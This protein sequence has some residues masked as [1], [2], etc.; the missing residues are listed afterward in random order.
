MVY[1]CA[2]WKFRNK[3]FN[4]LKIAGYASLNLVKLDPLKI[5]EIDIKQG[6]ESPVNINLKIQNSDLIGI[7][8]AKALQVK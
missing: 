1:T 6:K 8:R 4:N 7:K 3:S 5:S 2:Y